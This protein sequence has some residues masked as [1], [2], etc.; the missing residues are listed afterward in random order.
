MAS[1][2]AELLEK[3]STRIRQLNESDAQLRGALPSAD[4]LQTLERT[5]HSSIELLAKACELYAS[6]TAMG[7]RTTRE[8]TSFTT[9]S[10]GELWTR[11]SRLATCW[12]RQRFV[13]TSDFVGICG[14]ATPDY[15][16]AQNA[17]LYLAA[18]F[19]PLPSGRENDPTSLKRI[20][21]ETELCCIVCDV[22]ELAAMVAVLG[23]CPTVR[24]VAVMNV[25]T[26]ADANLVATVARQT[27]ISVRTLQE[28]EQMGDGSP[29]P[30]I[31]PTKATNPLR[32]LLYTSGSTGSPKGAMFPENVWYQQWLPS[33]AIPFPFKANGVP[34]LTLSFLP[35]NHLAGLG[36]IH[37]SLSHGGT[38]YFTLK[39]DMSSFFEDVRLVRP[40]HLDI[41]PRLVDLIHGHY[42]QEVAQRS[43]GA[44]AEARASIHESVVQN[45]RHNYLGD[46]LVGVICSGAPMAR[47]LREFAKDCFQV[48]FFNRWGSTETGPLTFENAIFRGNII[49]YK[50]V[51]VPGFEGGS[52]SF[53]NGQLCVK[54]HRA[55]SGY[56]KNDDESKKLFDEDGYLKTGDVAEH[57]GRDQIVWIGRRNDVLKLSQGE[58]V[59]VWRLEEIYS[60]SSLIQQIYLYGNS[61]R[62]YL[63]GVVVP[64]PELL[65]A[66]SVD[67]PTGATLK[68]SIRIEIN[69]IAKA[70]QVKAYEFLRDFIV[71]TQP[72]TKENG[73]ITRT[74]KMSRASLKTRYAEPLER[75]YSD[76]DRG[77]AEGLARLLAGDGV[78]MSEILKT[79]LGI[80]HVTLS[81]TFAGL[82]GDSLDAVRVAAVVEELWGVSVPVAF[83]LGRGNTVQGITKFVEDA[84]AGRLREQGVTFEEV[85][86][87][88]ATVVRSD[89]L[90]LDKFW[91]A[92]ELLE[93]PKVATTAS[94]PKVFLLSG[95]NGFLGRFLLL[96]LL[97]HARAHGG[98]VIA[99]VRAETDASAR[100]RVAAAIGE[101]RFAGL[102]A[103]GRLTV[104]AGD[105]MQPRFGLSQ[106]AFDQLAEEVD[107]VIHNG[108]L[109][110]HAF[111]YPQLFESNVLGTVEVMRLAVRKRIKPIAFVSTVGLVGG[112]RR[113]T[114]VREDEDARALWS[115]R[116][117]SASGYGTGYA[118]SKWAGEILLSELHERFG[119]PVN[120]FRCTAIL[121]HS[122]AA[123]QINAPDFFARLLCGLVWTQMAPRSFYLNSTTNTHF[124]GLPV[125]FVARAIA[126]VSMQ[127]NDKCVIYHVAN[128]HWDDGVSLDTIVSWVRSYGYEIETI[129]D[130]AQWYSDFGTKLKRL[131]HSRLQYSPLPIIERWDRPIAGEHARLDATRFRERVRTISEGLDVPHLDEAFIHKCLSDLRSLGLIDPPA[132]S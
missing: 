63:L 21:N 14:A 132:G 129:D 102:W 18:T 1:S 28:L 49:D 52:D 54:A 81:D 13:R 119:V 110:N 25:N 22:E 3:A 33:A 99:V 48:P 45:M 58:Y 92:A 123:G 79:T 32:A 126:G 120:I 36:L 40:T 122:N 83:I 93:L 101:Q 108:A 96:E 97:G 31:V 80:E 38:V 104:I 41:V 114:A 47:E 5:C 42:Q 77:K 103:E 53:P 112:L 121:A 75:L 91:S 90:Q 10:F 6:R 105:L 68:Q 71:E 95:A 57:Q 66:H 118:T 98:K 9:F 127:P 117:V 72:F 43:T 29:E 67:D 50:L 88:G 44:S 62:P 61:E 86:G 128:A 100:G 70:N 85:H 34:L 15:V 125:D 27:R 116:P 76:L 56:F 55:V 46:R 65:S 39:S 113:T 2:N 73:L 24:S 84:V 59:V 74:G 23:D 131:D 19:V 124:D 12:A 78:P 111:S 20:V 11:T 7:I 17:C 37:Q 51:E 94:P 16:A 8:S 89:D 26:V 107:A 64:H 115:E 30:M 87:P 35:L 82:G 4:A 109:V 60:H 69:R 106:A 130:Y